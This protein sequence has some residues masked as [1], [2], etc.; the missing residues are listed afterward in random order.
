MWG[1]PDDRH[2]GQV[3]LTNDRGAPRESTSHAVDVSGPAH[4]GARADPLSGAQLQ[5]LRRPRCHL[6]RRGRPVRREQHPGQDRGRGMAGGRG[7]RQRPGTPG[8]SGPFVE[9]GQQPKQH[10]RFGGPGGLRAPDPQRQR[11]VFTATELPPGLTLDPA[12]GVVTGRPAQPG[13]FEV[14]FTASDCDG[15]ASTRQAGWEV[16]P[17]RGASDRERSPRSPTLLRGD[18]PGRG[19]PERACVRGGATSSVLSEAAPR[20]SARIGIKEQR[21]AD[22]AS[23]GGRDRCVG[24]AR[25]LRRTDR[26]RSGPCRGPAGWPPTNGSRSPRSSTTTWV[27]SPSRRRTSIPRRLRPRSRTRPRRPPA[28]CP[29]RRTTRTARSR[30]SSTT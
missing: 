25:E 29:T 20:L 14:T 6:A 19:V 15:N 13:S 24:G 22:R 2:P 8:A 28:P 10:G 3:G 23:S 30:S 27:P 18:R 16:G 1:A 4:T 5:L 9:V 11:V 17:R 21:S 26:G 12:T 7:G